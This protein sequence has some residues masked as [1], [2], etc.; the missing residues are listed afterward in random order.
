MRK[1]GRIAE[2]ASIFESF[3]D[4]A[5]LMLAAFIF[6]FAMI[7]ISSRLSG[8]HTRTMNGEEIAQLQAKLEQAKKDKERL[9]AEM[10]RLIGSD[11]GEQTEQVLK[12]AGLG[13]GKG[14]KDFDLFVEGLKHLPGRDLHMVVDATGSMHGVTTFLIPVLRVIALRSGKRLTAVSWYADKKT[15]TFHGSMAE[16]FDLL[17]QKA[18]FVGSDETIG[19]AFDKITKE[20]PLPSA[21]LLIGDEAPTDRVQYHAI[22]RPVFTLSLALNDSRT[23]VAFEKLARETGGRALHL[24]FH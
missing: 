16:M 23:E 17:M 21:Y 4:M 20:E 2:D 15:G 5:L 22:P 14:R 6:L 9:L 1:R 12:A 8:D 24:K 11:A 19:H 10:E 13:E 3:T 18:P 7:L